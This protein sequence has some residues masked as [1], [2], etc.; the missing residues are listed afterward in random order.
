MESCLVVSPYES[1]ITL[2]GAAPTQTSTMSIDGCNH[3]APFMLGE[4][5]RCVYHRA[6]RS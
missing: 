3:V 5:S 4:V 1:A 6:L 2:C